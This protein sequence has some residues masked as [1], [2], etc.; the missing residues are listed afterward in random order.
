[1]T[2]I[3][4]KKEY[5][6][7]ILNKYENA[8]R[9][10][11]FNSTEEFE[12]AR[13]YLKEVTDFLPEDS[14]FPRRIW[15]VKN[16]TYHIPMCPHCKATEVNWNEKKYTMFCSIQ[17]MT[18][19]DYKR[20]KM[21]NTCKER[22]GEI[23]FMKTKEYTDKFAQIHQEK[24]GAMSYLMTDE[25]KNKVKEVSLEKY[26]VEHHTQ[27]ESTKK[28][29]Y[30]TRLERYGE[31]NL[32]LIKEFRDKGKETLIQKYGVSHFSYTKLP[33]GA[34]E[35]LMN[36][37]WLRQKNHDEKLTFI[38]IAELLNV[39]LSTI[40]D[41]FEKHGIQKKYHAKSIAENAIAEFFDSIKIPY[42]RNYRT[43]IYPQEV[44]FYI[45]SHNLAIEYHGV[46]WHSVG[47]KSDITKDYHRNKYISCRDLRN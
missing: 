4:E 2:T 30:E 15:H 3:E 33:D 28:L 41:Y 12:T 7:E 21:R 40:L 31:G 10:I 38:E 1:M 37:E 6:I 46:Y 17:C 45:P 25:F 19:S 39:N 22:Y 32:G 43:L 13:R 44:D 14:I 18:A 11:R 26:G 20:E 5:L 47:V 35:K 34:L 9:K 16:N 29:K 27:A 36:A 8:A 24:Y 42:I 23:H